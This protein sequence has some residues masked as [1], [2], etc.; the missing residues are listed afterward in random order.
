MPRASSAGSRAV[1]ALSMPIPASL[2]TIAKA[3]CGRA[4]AKR[5]LALLL[6][7]RVAGRAGR[8]QQDLRGDGAGL[9]GEDADALRRAVRVADEAASHHIGALADPRRHVADRG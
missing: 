8:A 1:P 3:A 7:R 4:V 6:C 2:K 9:T 5:V